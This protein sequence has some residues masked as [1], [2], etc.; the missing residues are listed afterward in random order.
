MID[1]NKLTSKDIGRGVT[2]TRYN[3]YGIGEPVLGRIKS[4][5]DEWIF[6]V[7][8][9]D[10]DWKNYQEYTAAATRPVDLEFFYSREWDPD[11]TRFD[12]IDFD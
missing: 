10:N 12:L 6:V 7:Y 8:N 2:Y 9:C 4:W 3:M 11:I 1:L 5:N